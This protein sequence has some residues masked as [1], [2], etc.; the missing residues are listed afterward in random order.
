MTVRLPSSDVRRAAALRAELDRA[1]SAMVPGW[2]VAMAPDSFGRALREIAARFAEETSSRLD[3]TAERDTLAFFD[4]LDIPPPA[5]QAATATLVF[6]TEEARTTA[7]SAPLRVQVG[8]TV[9]NQDVIFETTRALEVSPARIAE[10]VAVDPD[11]DHIERAPGRVLATERP[12]NPVGGRLLVTAASAGSRIVQVDPAIGLEPG[13]QLRIPIQGTAYRI[14]SVSQDLVTLVD[15]L[16][17]A[18]PA[19][20]PFQKIEALEAF[21]LRDLQQHACYV[22]HMSLLNLEG[23]ARIELVLTPSG[24]A[25]RLAGL[26]LRYSLWGTKDGEDEP[27]WQALELVGGSATTLTV[28]KRWEGSV[29]ELK[30]DGR[31]S[32]WLRVEYPQPITT[33]GVG[34][35]ADRVRLT[36]QSE[37]PAAAATSTPPPEPIGS[38]TITNAFHNAAPLAVT[39]RFLPFGL[40]P[41]R[42]DIFAFAAPEA[43]SKPGARVDLDIRVADASLLALVVP[44]NA[45][46]SSAGTLAYGIGANG[47]LH[48][49]TISTGAD[50]RWRVLPNLVASD[51]AP[52]VLD[53]SAGLLAL[54]LAAGFAVDILVARDRAGQLWYGA[55]LAGM[56]VFGPWRQ[57]PDGDVPIGDLVLVPSVGS[58][59]ST[60]ACLLRVDGGQ[61]RTFGFGTIGQPAAAWD[62]VQRLG[63]I[64]PN[65]DQPMALAPVHGAT[66]VG[67][68]LIET[69]VVLA[70]EDGAAWLG[71][72]SATPAGLAVAWR[73]LSSTGARA[74]VRPAATLDPRP[75]G[76]TQLWVAWADVDNG[77]AGW[78]GTPDGVSGDLRDAG[79]GGFDAAPGSSLRVAAQP[80]APSTI[81][82]LTTAVAGDNQGN[83][84]ILVWFDE[85]S[86][87]EASL[88]ADATDRPPTDLVI[89]EPPVSLVPER[90]LLVLPATGEAL[91][92]AALDQLPATPLTYTLHDGLAIKG[93]ADAS[94]YVE[95]NGGAGRRIVP[96]SSP[97]EIVQDD[98]RVYEVTGGVAVGETFQFLRRL[99][100]SLQNLNGDVVAMDMLRLDSLDHVTNTGRHLIIGGRTFEVIAIDTSVPGQKTAT[101]DEPLTDPVGSTVPYTPVRRQGTGGTVTAGDV[102]TLVH[103]SDVVAA[104]LTIRFDDGTPSLHPR[105]PTDLVAEGRWWRVAQ[106]WTTAPTLGTAAVLGSSTIGSWTVRVLERGYDNPEL[107]WEF[108]DGEG[109]RLLE[110]GFVDGTQDLATSG[111]VSFRVPAT[112]SATDIGGREDLWIRVRLVGGDY[113]RPKYVVTTTNPSSSTSVQ[114]T[115]I[116]TSDLHP[117]EITSIEASF[118]LDAATAPESVL[119]VDNLATLD[120]T[121]ASAADQARFALFTGARAIDPG[122][123]GRALYVGLTRQPVSPLVLYAVVDDQDVPGTLAVDVLTAAGWQH[124]TVDDET[125]ALHRTGLT[126]VFLST[127]LVRAA[128]FG[129]EGF[130]LRLRPATG[131]TG[132]DPGA[133]HPVVR[134]LFVNGVPA[135]QARTI[136]QEILGSSLGEPSLTLELAETPVLP[137]TLELRVREQL[138][139][140]EQKALEEEWRRL[141]LVGGRPR[142]EAAPVVGTVTGVEGTWV[143]WRRV[144]SFIGTDGDA[145]VY[146]L[147]PA[148]GRVTFGD[149]RQGKV[150]PA[151]RDAI[152]AFRYQQGGGRQGN[153]S[154]WSDLAVKSALEGIEAVVLPVD[155]AGGVDNPD[156]VTLLDTAPARLRH[157]GQALAVADYEALAVAAAP[158]VVRARCAR[159]DRPGDA[160]RVAISLRDGTRRPVPSLAMRAAVTRTL[161]SAGWGGL[162]TRRLRVDPPRYVDVAVA[163]GLRVPAA[164]AAQVEQ[165]ATA[166]LVQLLHPTDGGPDGGGWPF[167]RRLWES[168]VLRALDGVDGIDRVDDVELTRLDGRPLDAMPPD[169]LISAAPGDVN[170]QIEPVVE[171]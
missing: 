98:D 12:P 57:V 99:G 27:A 159:P 26:D 7:T 132:V 75:N 79:T 166:A 83:R 56:L 13:D 8:A 133:W 58:R 10:V 19:G 139:E 2:G 67:T 134:G 112:L 21:T 123:D 160:I 150:P 46:S 125:G 40:T 41:A 146:R 11:T 115:T 35:Q 85:G 117:P 161:H 3:R 51:G 95:L 144:E 25:A 89:V 122:I 63:A 30:L 74:D 106:A 100:S 108:F 84:S 137:E 32:R 152:R 114:S 169:G 143:L 155:A 90:P 80:W 153:A 62:T 47:L 158:E 37:A 9:E 87:E 162:P 171:P 119:A 121:Q 65:L 149:G 17:A 43:L 165:A 104:G 109:W 91:V 110:Q 142:S 129:Q 33:V 22:G 103:L 70:A 92:A 48:S 54:R 71:R 167:G 145:R 101:L 45:Q 34:A 157:A 68:A 116:D 50:V 154:A 18:V 105:R 42:F 81:Q 24:L 1:G 120:Q 148:S 111:T 94:H 128:R 102:Q 14:E 88:P 60:P 59:T 86:A 64:G 130:W 170:V 96:L 135:K 15:P 118:V 52:V 147:D 36:V 82:P 126:Q 156:P 163:V 168:D 140:D 49:V 151:G 23:P 131:T 16:A 4:T 136:V 127:P 77:I 97:A 55:V 78:L 38:R 6:V 107:S 61:L 66:S 72:I 20:T 164:L 124:A 141:I 28:R 138:S 39:D 31:K 113:G 73:R 29:D 44:L 76:Q 93:V 69:D 5:P 53:G